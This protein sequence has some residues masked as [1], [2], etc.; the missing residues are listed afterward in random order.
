ML[1]LQQAALLGV[2]LSQLTGLSQTLSHALSAY[3]QVENG[4]VV[5]R[6]S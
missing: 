4:A 6:C 2:A 1:M 5:S 3:A